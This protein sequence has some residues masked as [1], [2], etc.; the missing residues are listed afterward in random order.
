MIDKD[1]NIWHIYRCPVCSADMYISENSKSIFCRGERRHCF[2]FSSE[3]Y[4]NLSRVR[5]GDSKGAVNARRDFLSGGYYKPLAE[6]VFEVTSELVGGDAVILDAGCGEGYFT[7]FIAGTVGF[8]VGVDLSKFAVAVGMKAANRQ[9]I[10]NVSY[11][12]GSVFELP[13]ADG[14][15]DC[16]TSIMAP[17]A[18]EENARLLKGDG[19]VILVSAGK[20]HLMGLKEALYESTYENGERSDVPKTHFELI[21]RVECKYDVVVEGDK[22]IQNLFAMTPYYWRTSEADK[23]KLERLETLTTVVDFNV[24]VY[25]KKR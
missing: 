24:D 2:D 11:I 7:N 5:G 16:I 20:N 6:C 18:E 19:A 21:K 23:A 15:F 9:G 10:S 17:F 3:G 22:D 8:A 1:S 13:F 25:R 12:T 4:L 14:S